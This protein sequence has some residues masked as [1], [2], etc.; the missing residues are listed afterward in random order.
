MSNET[1]ITPDMKEPIAAF[2]HAPVFS[3]EALL[4][5]CVKQAPG[6]GWIMEFGVASGYSTGIIK[7]AAGNRMVYGFDS[8]QGLPA[9]WMMATD[10]MWPKGA[11]GT[12][13]RT[14]NIE[15]VTFLCGMF[16]DTIPLFLHRRTDELAA[17]ISL[18]CD[19]YESAK[20]VLNLMDHKI[21]TGT[22]IYFDEI[23]DWGGGDDRYPLWPQGEYRAFCEWLG[24]DRQVRVIGRNVRYGAAVEVVACQ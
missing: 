11:F 4:E 7:K 6:D 21:A 3:V 10:R 16:A 13:G 2:C 19:L 8:F 24:R 15:G 20:T 1:L 22:I 5:R 14:P 17:F 9:D 12:G 23:C 18:D